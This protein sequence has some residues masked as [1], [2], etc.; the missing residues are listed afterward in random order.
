MVRLNCD[1]PHFVH[2]Q[3]FIALTLLKAGGSGTHIGPANLWKAY[4]AKTLMH[5]TFLVFN[6]TL[7]AIKQFEQ[8]LSKLKMLVKSRYRT[9]IFPDT[10]KKRLF[11]VTF[12]KL[13][14]QT[15]TQAYTATKRQTNTKALFKKVL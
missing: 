12:P 14:Q 5:I 1:T 13:I 3:T 8:I 11:C 6:H 7:F 4:N 2:E 9:N 10:S 15:D